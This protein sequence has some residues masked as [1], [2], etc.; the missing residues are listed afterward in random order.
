MSS[1]SPSKSRGTG[2]RACGRGSAPWHAA[3]LPTLCCAALLFTGAP[4]LRAEPAA[5]GPALFDSLQQQVQKL[6]DKS[7]EAVVRVEAADEHG[8]V[9][10]TGFFV[11]PNGTLYTSYTVGGDTHDIVVVRGELKFPARCVAADV[12]CGLAILK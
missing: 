3:S 11:D 9:S 4:I 7:R 2:V 8:L 10:G 5:E 1:R 12:R 6:F